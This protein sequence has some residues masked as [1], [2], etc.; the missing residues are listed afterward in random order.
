MSPGDQQVL[1]VAVVTGAAR[2]IGAAIAQRLAADG[3]AVAVADLDREACS[4]T[5]EAIGSAGGKAAAFAIDVAQ[6]GSVQEG[7]AQIAATLGPPTVLVNNA[8]TLRERTLTRTSLDEWDLM[9]NVNLRGAFLMSRQVVPY[10]RAAGQGRIVNL[11]STGALGAPGL[12]AYSSAKAGLQGFTRTLAMELGR[13]GVTVNAVAPGFVVS[14]MTSAVAERTGVDF[15]QMQQ[16]IL[17]DIP[18]GRV[19]QPQDIAQ[20]VAFFVDARSS[21]ISGQVLYVAGGP[22]G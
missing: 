18:L 19:G 13:Y 4:A 12:A 16:Q 9:L 15:E 14:A 1:R 3:L 7:V 8:G 20:A 2:G 11:S 21:Y 17:K 10:Q 6:E 5:V 22:R